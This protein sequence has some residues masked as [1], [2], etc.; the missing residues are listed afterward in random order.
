M[1]GRNL[2]RLAGA[3]DLIHGLITTEPVVVVEMGW[4]SSWRPAG[5]RAFVTTFGGTQANSR[6]AVEALGLD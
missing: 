4:P 3:A 6:A 1:A 5:A 2:H